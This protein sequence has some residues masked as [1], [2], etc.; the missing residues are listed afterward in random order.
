VRGGAAEVLKVIVKQRSK[1]A[2]IVFE[3]HT[4]AVVDRSNHG[5]LAQALHQR[6]PFSFK[7]SHP[8]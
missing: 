7:E 2:L 3:Q 8:P 1:E 5:S 6:M 4:E